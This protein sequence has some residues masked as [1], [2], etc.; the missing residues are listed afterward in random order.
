MQRDCQGFK[1][2]NIKNFDY[3]K[4]IS[5]EIT[6]DFCNNE[7]LISKTEFYSYCINLYKKIS[8]DELIASYKIDIHQ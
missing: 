5:N 1:H 8:L 2:L 7:S 6:L 3:I 4:E